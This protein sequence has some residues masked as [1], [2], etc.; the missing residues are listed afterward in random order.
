MFTQDLECRFCSD[1]R[2]LT[3]E[4]ATLSDKID[5]D[6]YD[7]LADNQKAKEYG[8]DKIPAVAV[9]GKVD[10]GLRIY[11]IPYGYELQTLVEAIINVSRGTTDLTIKRKPS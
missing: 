4:L 1:T 8:I 2:I 11:G 3:Q 10:H 5:V 7:F 6:V 9:I